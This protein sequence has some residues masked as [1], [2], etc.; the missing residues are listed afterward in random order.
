MSTPSAPWRRDIPQAGNSEADGD[1][2]GIREAAPGAPRGGSQ[3]AGVPRWGSGQQVE[4]RARSLGGRV[5]R[6]GKVL[7]TSAASRFGVLRRAS[8]RCRP[9]RQ[10]SGLAGGEDAAKQGLAAFTERV[11]GILRKHNSA[12]I[13]A[14]GDDVLALLPLDTAIPAAVDLQQAYRAAFGGQK[15]AARRV[16]VGDKQGRAGPCPQPLY[17]LNTT[18]RCALCW[19]R[20]TSSWTTIS[21]R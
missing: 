6:W 1:Q 3:G 4:H 21:S 7:S 8:G 13:Y 20:R 18:S 15:R 17:S 19:R 10:E 14:G 11:F 9:H 16:R 12:T 2:G 5:R